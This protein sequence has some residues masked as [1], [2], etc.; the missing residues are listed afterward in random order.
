MV[1][2]PTSICLWPIDYIAPNG[3]RCLREGI[4]TGQW[5]RAM[6]PVSFQGH[7]INGLTSSHQSLPTNR[8]NAFQE[9]DRAGM[10]HKINRLLRELV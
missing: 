3:W 5:K 4:Q 10:K 9:C 8:P 7:A 1:S 6:E 2:A